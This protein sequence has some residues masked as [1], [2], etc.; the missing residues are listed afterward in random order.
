MTT[1]AKTLKAVVS[2][3]A[4]MIAAGKYDLVNESVTANM[5][6]TDLVVGEEFDVSLVSF[7]HATLNAEVLAE[8]DKLAL[9]PIDLKVLEALVATNPDILSE[10]PIVALGTIWTDSTGCKVSP[11]VHKTQGKRNLSLDW[12]DEGN[13]WLDTSLFAAVSNVRK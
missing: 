13:E 4:E 9:R 1:V 3:V 8:L 5:P 2:T 12:N 10:A 7:G 6:I 11:L